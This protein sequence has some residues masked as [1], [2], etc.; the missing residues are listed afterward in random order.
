ML[1]SGPAWYFDLF[2]RIGRSKF[3]K[4]TPKGMRGGDEQRLEPLNL[5]PTKLQKKRAKLQKMYDKK[6]QKER[7]KAD[8]IPLNKEQDEQPNLVIEAKGLIAPKSSKVRHMTDYE[9]N[10]LFNNTSNIDLQQPLTAG[11][12]G[13]RSGGRNLYG[14]KCYWSPT[15]SKSPKTQMIEKAKKQ[16]SD[17]GSK[18]FDPPTNYSS[19]EATNGSPIKKNNK[20]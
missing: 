14:Y 12:T 9:K 11:S 2:Y 17:E 7:E 13:S 10:K 8:A 15:K 5:S 20:K 16:C 19:N 18:Q 1:V 4:D 3:R 6:R